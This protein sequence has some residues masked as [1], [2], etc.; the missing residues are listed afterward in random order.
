MTTNPPEFN[1]PPTQCDIDQI[2]CDFLSEQINPYAG[3]IFR[4]ALICFDRFT[5]LREASIKFNPNSN[6]I[7]GG[8]TADGEL[9]LH[10]GTE[11]SAITPRIKSR[12]TER[13]G[14]PENQE[15]PDGFYKLFVLAHEIGHVIQMDPLFQDFYGPYDS[16][17]ID[18]QK[19][20]EEYVYSEN[21]VLA[22]FIACQIIS[23]SEIGAALG[24]LP[25]T[26]EP[27]EWRQWGDS[28]RVDKT[29]ELYGHIVYDIIH[30]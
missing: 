20:Y 17:V 13:F 26:E 9:M 10:I 1:R 14:L 15:F 7:S 16:T 29:L 18:A 25:P 30:N 27:Q 2:K 6:F 3:D 23:N 11:E 21:E 4:S 28:H 24:I 12:I 22:D 19:K 5:A 8:Q